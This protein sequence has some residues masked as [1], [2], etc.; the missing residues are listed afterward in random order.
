MRV[1][2]H[3][4]KGYL[5]T[6]FQIRNAEKDNISY[7]VYDE[8]NNCVSEGVVA[9]NEPHGV[10]MPSA[11]EFKITINNE[12]DY[13]IFVE[14]AFKYGGNT[15][16]KAFVFDNTP[17]SF[18]V[19]HDRT[20]FY[21]RDTEESYV[22]PISPDDIEEISDK[23]V[24]LR[25]KKQ[26]E[27]TIY[28]LELQKPILWIN[29]LLFHN[30]KCVCW[31][32]S[33][34]EKKKIIVFS[35][36]KLSIMQRVSFEDFSIN[37]KLERVFI[38]NGNHIY[39]L[40]FQDDMADLFRYKYCGTFICFTKDSYV[41]SDVKEYNSKRHYIFI[42]RGYDGTKCGQI[43]VQGTLARVNDTVL[44]DTQQRINTIK[45]LRAE[46]FP[47]TEIEALYSEY[48]IYASKWDIFFTEKLVSIHFEQDNH[49][50]VKNVSVNLK[51]LRS[52]ISQELMNNNLEYNSIIT[53]SFFLL[54][55]QKES[56]VFP[57]DNPYRKSYDKNVSIYRFN[58]Q[59]YM[60]F[61]DELFFLSEK[62]VWCSCSIKGDLD[63][64][65]L[66]HFGVVYDNKSKK[67][68]TT[69]GEEFKGTL[70][71]IY[72]PT[73]YLS[74]NNNRIYPK[75]KII[76]TYDCPTYLSPD[77][78]YGLTVNNDSIYLH[79]LENGDY[80]RQTRILED[81]FDTKKYMNV[82]LSDN[83]KQILYRENN[84]SK[85]LDL[86]TGETI[87]FKN[88]SHISHINGM[89]PLFSVYETSQANLINPLTGQAIDYRLVSQYQF[90]SPDGKLFADKA[91]GK[92][93]EYHD[94]INGKVY[95]QEQK[96]EL[97]KKLNF[98][99]LTS[100]EEK[101]IIQ[102]NREELI[103]KSFDFLVERYKRSPH[104]SDANKDWKNALRE[105]RQFTDLFI[106][107][108]GIAV[109]KRTSD[110]SEVARIELGE[111]L[112]FLNY[113][114]FSDDSRYVAIAGKYKG[115]GGLLLIYDL[116]EKHVVA[117]S[118]ELLAVWNVA[119]SKQGAVAAYTSSPTTFFAKSRTD[120]KDVFSMNNRIKLSSFLTFSPD[121]D[122]FACSKQGYICYKDSE[123]R[124]NPNW[125]HQ[126]SSLV[127]IRKSNDPQKEIANY[128]DLSE[129]GIAESYSKE[130]VASVSFS[131][132]NKHIMMVGKDGVV[133]VRNIHLEK[134]INHK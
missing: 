50:P 95:N 94:L 106:V 104:P 87:D 99:F 17:W 72:R 45:E 93:T 126:P 69:T 64:S 62:G 77:Y 121:G 35:L 65:D 2:I 133:I 70:G 60:L 108:K 58:N 8:I 122:Y 38:K 101:K 55:S 127:S 34:E 41:I 68:L 29:N 39:W 61:D 26:D 134:M 12:A 59:I 49:N 80:S 67:Y 107:S 10:I 40:S 111:P 119:F 113:V 114:S 110:Q 118:N 132:D 74:I 13:N 57:K 47:E 11:G 54:Y 125:G 88:L 115:K 1:F 9:P 66:S 79:V 123:G 51:S 117:S 82:F 76:R 97:A 7:K 6:K 46:H 14:D 33:G 85:I 24:V 112:W 28:S 36:E 23:F 81:I 130:S 15:L 116:E 21:N 37:T 63:L 131:D 78:N 42:C 120:Y 31:T 43:E 5:N 109:I 18:V 84:Q 83:G 53:D 19:M 105:C 89:R 91:L 16:K 75:G 4:H 90:V 96:N 22:E 44:I 52:N 128:S 86:S 71:H 3:P 124:I 73:E 103:K 102:D 27:I 129:N 48:Y 25:T 20:Y 92:Y 32:E 100:E 30:S 98:S 56:F